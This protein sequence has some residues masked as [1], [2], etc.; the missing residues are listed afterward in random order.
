MGHPVTT[1][2]MIIMIINMTV[3]FFVLM[4]LMILIKAIHFID[5]TKPK[6]E[7][8]KE[9]MLAPVPAPAAEPAPVP[10]ETGIPGEVI[11]VITAAMAA[12]GYSAGQIHAVRPLE[13]NGW[14]VSG[15]TLLGNRLG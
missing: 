9:A 7:P 6:E 11:A 5:P 14:K 8:K 4:A 15:R 1:N 10:A 13:R 12:Y 2:P 3:V